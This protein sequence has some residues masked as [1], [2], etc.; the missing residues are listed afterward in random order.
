MNKLLRINSVSRC[1]E[2][3]PVLEDI[4]FS[5]DKKEYLSI[6][7]PSGVGKSTLLHIMGG[8]DL[9]NKGGILYKGKN[10]YKMKDKQIC[11]WRN[12]AIGFV[13]QFYYLIEELTV[14]ENVI[15]PSLVAKRSRKT[16]L[17][18]A[19]KLLKYLSILD[20]VNNVP[21]QLSGG[22]RQKVA[23]ARALINNP[24]IVFCDEP[25]GNLDKDSAENI[26][27]LLEY[28]NKEENI[29]VVIVTHNQDIANR[30][31]RRIK[32]REGKIES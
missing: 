6:V 22:Q 21:S 18:E 17:K 5:V 32:L 16:S 29:T 9:P 2:K 15:L 10:I 13:F 12:K 11:E 19:E 14:L 31:H 8:L 26:I 3:T 1:Y 7:G 24:E 4:S 30:A 23:V 27:D 28:L 25:T 20:K